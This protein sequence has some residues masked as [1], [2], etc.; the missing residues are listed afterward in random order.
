M[1]Q[2][3][4]PIQNCASEAGEPRDDIQDQLVSNNYAGKKKL[5]ISLGEMTLP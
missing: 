1:L 5:L 4:Q 2:H 3:S